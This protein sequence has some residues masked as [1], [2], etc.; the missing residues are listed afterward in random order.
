M[1]KAILYD[2]KNHRHY[3]IIRNE[4]DPVPEGFTQ[5]RPLPGEPYQIYDE[6]AGEWAVD[7]DSERLKEIAKCKAE[8]AGIDRETGT[9]RAA[10]S[11][12]LQTA[13]KAGIP[14]EEGSDMDRLQK[15]EDRANEL[16]A[17]NKELEGDK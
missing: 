16:R 14:V 13:L 12:I 10:R 17:R 2:K 7:P 4:G 6:A 11:L 8:L 9:G 1:T 3:A 5:S 15:K